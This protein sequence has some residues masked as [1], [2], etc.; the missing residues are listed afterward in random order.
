MLRSVRV[1]SEG[2]V[3]ERAAHVR[4]AAPIK[5]TSIR[6]EAH[7]TRSRVRE[8]DAG[9]AASA[10]GALNASSISNLASAM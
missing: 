7:M 4:A 10:C 1:V 5:P 6:A 3:A 2:S 9:T 8:V